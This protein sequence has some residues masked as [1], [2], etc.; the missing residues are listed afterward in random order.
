MKLGNFT[1]AKSCFVKAVRAE[2]NAH[3]CDNVALALYLHSLGAALLKN[4]EPDSAVDQLER[5]LRLERT[6]NGDDSSG[7][8]TALIHLGHAYREVGRLEDAEATYREALNILEQDASDDR[9]AEI[10]KLLASLGIVQLGRRQFGQARLFLEQAVARQAELHGDDS[11]LLVTVLVNLGKAMD[12]LQAPT[13]AKD[14]YQRALT[15]LEEK[16]PENHSDHATILYRLGR[17]H[18]MEREYATAVEFYERA[19]NMGTRHLGQEHAHVARDA[20]GLGSALAAQND[21]IVAMGHLTLALDIYETA[22]GKDHPKTR[23][24]RKKLDKISH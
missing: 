14:S 12:G 16:N 21:T 22:M 19:M 20:A 23:A 3:N 17:S 18:E 4:K 2:E 11:E 1:R 13:Q 15:I 8:P 10:A 24:V 5:A 9:G 6:T 7:I